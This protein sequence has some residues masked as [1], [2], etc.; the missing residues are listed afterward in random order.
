MMLWVE[1]ASWAAFALL[2]W[3]PVLAELVPAAPAIGAPAWAGTPSGPGWRAAPAVEGERAGPPVV[4]RVAE[5]AVR[6]R[7]VAE[8]AAMRSV[9]SACWRAQAP[10]ARNELL[11]SV[12]RANRGNR[13]QFSQ[14]WQPERYRRVSIPDAIMSKVSYPKIELHVHLEGTVRPAAL[15]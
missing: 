8:E 7:R 4:P 6:R 15:L 13:F 10:M 9:R 5:R 11:I 1:S 2:K 3:S 14:K 12:G